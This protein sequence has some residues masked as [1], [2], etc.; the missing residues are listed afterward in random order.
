MKL[1]VIVDKAEAETALIPESFVGH[2][3][4]RVPVEWVE[5]IQ[6]KNY[7][8]H[9]IISRHNH[10]L[11]RASTNIRHAWPISAYTQLWYHNPQQRVLPQMLLVLL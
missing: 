2:A 3:L 10:F 7:R 1:R 5:D 9:G 11:D 8:Q 6:L 4:V